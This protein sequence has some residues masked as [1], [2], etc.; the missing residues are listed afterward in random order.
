MDYTCRCAGGSGRSVKRRASASKRAA[1]TVPAI[2]KHFS[3]RCGPSTLL[4]CALLIP[5]TTGE[6][7]IVVCR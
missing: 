7:I 1:R 2:S 4:S 6:T 5:S 3:A